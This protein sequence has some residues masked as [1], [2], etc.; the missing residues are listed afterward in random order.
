MGNKLHGPRPTP[1]P[2]GCIGIL[3]IFAGSLFAG[4]AVASLIMVAI[5]RRKPI[6]GRYL[7][8]LWL[9][10]FGWG[11]VLARRTFVGASMDCHLLI[12][13]TLSMHTRHFAL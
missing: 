9:V 2:Y 10:L 6:L 7:W 8:R 4:F 12:Q 11:W 13:M 5:H 1:Q 3:L